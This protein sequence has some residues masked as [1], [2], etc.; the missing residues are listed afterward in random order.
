MYHLITKDSQ[1]AFYKEKAIEAAFLC[2]LRCRKPRIPTLKTYQM[3]KLRKTSADL[4][5]KEME[6]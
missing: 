3:S 6:L 2:M 1:I 4:L 5:R